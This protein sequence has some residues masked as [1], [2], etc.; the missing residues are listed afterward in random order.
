MKDS[1]LLQQVLNVGKAWQVTRVAADS[2]AQ[3][4]DVWIAARPQRTGWFTRARPE[5]G[6]PERVWR[7]TNVGVWRCMIHVRATDDQRPQLVPWCGDAEMPFTRALSR[8]IAALLVDGVKIPTICNLLD[9]PLNDLWKFKF[10]L[11]AGKTGLGLAAP[12]R[13]ETARGEVATTA[14][15]APAPAGAAVPDMTHPVWERL[16]EGNLEIEVRVLGLKLLLT[17]LRDQMRAIDDVEVRMLKI[18]EIH[19]YFSRH[20]KTLGHELA[21]LARA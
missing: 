9:V 20:A 10:N 17:K 18:H 1:E 12:A 7:H 14:G 3:V 16:L 5:A 8:Q 11:D 19:R 4:L 13:A 21:Q 6:G 2:E 15:T